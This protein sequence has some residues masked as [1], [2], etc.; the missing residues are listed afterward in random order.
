M[1]TLIRIIYS[2]TIIL[3]ISLNACRDKYEP[4]ECNYIINIPDTALKNA[5]LKTWMYYGNDREGYLDENGDGEI[6][7]GEAIRLETFNLPNEADVKSFEGIQYF[8][9]LKDLNL[10]NCN[11]DSISL[12]S[13]TIIRLGCSSA[14]LTKLDVSKLEN[15]TELDSE[16]LTRS[17]LR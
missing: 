8:S 7:D 1:K 5:L 4:A 17:D 12:S 15:L 11:L 9:R 13:S 3:L 14:S 16:Q 10:N 2:L 6:C